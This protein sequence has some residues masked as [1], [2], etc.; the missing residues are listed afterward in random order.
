MS[1]IVGLRE[2]TFNFILSLGFG[3]LAGVLYDVVRT[4]R[5]MISNGKKAFMIF[6]IIYAVFA[7]ILTF[8]FSLVITNGTIM[9]YVIFGE[10]LGFFIYYTTFGVFVIKMSDKITAFLKKIFKAIFKAICCPFKWT[11][12]H[13]RRILG[14]ISQKSRKKA[15]KAVKKS[16]FHL[17]VYNK[18]LYNQLDNKRRLRKNEGKLKGNGSKKEESS[19][20]R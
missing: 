14:K 3:F 17:K 16:K 6:D 5:M 4:V 1:Y 15:E 18:L 10:L 7:A 12:E 9:G 13:L 2:Q 19:Q 8:I 11:F 20:K